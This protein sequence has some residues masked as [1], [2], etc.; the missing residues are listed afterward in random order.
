MLT[1]LTVTV[2][3]HI[4][5]KVSVCLFDSIS[6]TIGLE[7]NFERCDHS[8]E[9][10]GALRTNIRLQFRSNQNPFTVTLSPLSV[11]ATETLGLGFFINSDGIVIT[12][13]DVNISY[14]C[15]KYQWFN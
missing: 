4:S 15:S 10:G 6:L 3:Q 12:S 13:V 7:I 8:I 14:S 9:E 11:D 2:R 5:H 1:S